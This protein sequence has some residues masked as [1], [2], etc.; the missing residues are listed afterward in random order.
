MEN[1]MS[2]KFSCIVLLNST[3]LIALFL[4]QPDAPKPQ[5]K[6][7]IWELK[8]AKFLIDN[9]TCEMCE[10]TVHKS[11]SKV[12]GVIKTK[13]DYDNQSAWVV[14]DGLKNNVDA[15][16]LASTNAGYTA[17]LVLVNP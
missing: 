2:K 7:E 14:F 4:S 15:I 3:L 17:T 1:M 12:G 13:V 16:A 8:I 11:I 10:I 6:Q 5:V 9:M